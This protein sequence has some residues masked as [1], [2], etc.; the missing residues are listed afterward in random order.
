MGTIE[1]YDDFESGGSAEVIDFS[2]SYGPSDISISYENDQ[3][4]VFESSDGGS[5]TLK[6][7]DGKPETI[8]NYEEVLK[9]VRKLL[10]TPE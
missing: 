2:S 4:V 6:T 8:P 1:E 5:W 10:G 9:L 3:K 7:A